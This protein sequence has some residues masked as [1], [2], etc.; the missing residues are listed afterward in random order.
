MA[1][2][3]GFFAE[4]PGRYRIEKL[5]EAGNYE[6]IYKNDEILVKA[7]QY[8]IVTA[9][10]N[11]P[12]GEAVFKREEREVG[13][14]VRVYFSDGENVYNNFDVLRAD[15]PAIEFLPEKA[16]YR[17]TFGETEVSTELFVTE[18]GKRFIMSVTLKNLGEKTKE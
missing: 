16:T 1:E 6:Y 17:L 5:P 14:P 2:Q 9:Q 8:G 11:P 13:S 3:Y 4:Q 18:K 12:V 10:I 7:D 15:K